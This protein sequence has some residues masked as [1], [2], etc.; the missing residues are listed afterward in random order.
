MR[1]VRR[2]RSVSL[3]FNNLGAYSLRPAENS[4][5]KKDQLHNMLHGLGRG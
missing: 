2:R 1:F 5:A 3:A 4:R